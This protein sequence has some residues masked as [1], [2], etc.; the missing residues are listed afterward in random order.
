[1]PITVY[2]QEGPRKGERFCK[3]Y[4]CG[5]MFPESRYAEAQEHE[6]NPPT[7][8]DFGK[9]LFRSGAGYSLLL[10]IGL[11]KKGHERQY[12][13]WTLQLEV[14][15]GKATWGSDLLEKGNRRMTSSVIQEKLVSGEFNGVTAE[16]AEEVASFISERDILGNYRKAL[17]GLPFRT[18]PR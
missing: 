17:G 13:E 7:G 1:M 3:C 18:E 12:N 16:Q 15:T 6:M 10:P 8:L 4:Q 9:V 2:I 5:K 14:C 11:T